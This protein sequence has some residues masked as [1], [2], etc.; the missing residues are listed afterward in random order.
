MKK[1]SFLVCMLFCAARAD[2]KVNVVTTVQTFKSLVEAIGGDR[3][4]VTA[5]VGEN[6]DPHYVDA[7]PSYALTLNRAQLLVHVG[8]ELEKG[9]LPPLLAQA[10]NPKIQVGQRGNLDASSTGI[11]VREAAAVVSRAAGDIHP[12]GNPH[13]WLMPDAALA[14]ARAIAERLSAIDPDG[15]KVY[16]ERLTAFTEKLG[17][18]RRAWE[19]AGRALAGVKVVTYHRSWAYLT[20]WLRLV[21]IGSIEPKPGVPPS[22]SHL[23]GL[24]ERAKQ[25]GA[26]LVLVE[27][28]YPR[29]TA[30]RV[31]AMAGMKLVVL[32]PDGADY[33]ALM[34]GILASLTGAA[35]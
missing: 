11:E 22:P 23:A 21:E 8:L 4:T 2:A 35:R 31:A 24:V 5:L 14:V 18:R 1:I 28:F 16:A 9:W 27:S 20:A 15:A 7:K 30:E 19:E 33:F 6:V 10:R 13:Y 12:L 3:V 32:P 17:A 26:R 29:N 25:E 34:D